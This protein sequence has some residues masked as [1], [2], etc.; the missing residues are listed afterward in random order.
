MLQL[1]GSMAVAV[2]QIIP[3]ILAVWDMRGCLLTANVW[4]RKACGMMS[5]RM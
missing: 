5:R 1:D 3:S 4:H 2:F